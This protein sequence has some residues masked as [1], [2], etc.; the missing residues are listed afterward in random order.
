MS[1][2]SD[3]DAILDRLTDQMREQMAAYE[4]KQKAL[5]DA[6]TPEQKAVEKATAEREAAYKKTMHARNRNH[7][8]DYYDNKVDE[9]DPNGLVDDE[10]LEQTKRYI[11]GWHVSKSMPSTDS[12]TMTDGSHEDEY[13]QVNGVYVNGLSHG[14]WTVVAKKDVVGVLSCLHTIPRSFYSDMFHAAGT[15]ISIELD[16]GIIKSLEVK[17]AHGETTDVY[18]YYLTTDEKN[19]VIPHEHSVK[20]G[21]NS[22]VHMIDTESSNEVYVRCEDGNITTLEI[23]AD[24][25]FC[26]SIKCGLCD[27]LPKEVMFEMGETNKRNNKRRRKNRRLAKKRRNW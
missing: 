1:F 9:A 26:P 19:K 14:Q 3:N 6:K 2:E 25:R 22:V 11:S 23:E 10:G 5:E 16:N 13:R 7:D 18:S 20:Y 27:S 4:A 8:D 24:F 15:S 17:D 21:E 12:K